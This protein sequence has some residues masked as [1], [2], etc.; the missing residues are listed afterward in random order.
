MTSDKT[1]SLSGRGEGLGGGGWEGRTQGLT[2]EHHVGLLPTSAETTQKGEARPG[3]SLGGERAR[4]GSRG[5]GGR[6]TAHQGWEEVCGLRPRTLGGGR[7]AETPG[8]QRE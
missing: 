6:E 1:G 3:S 2:S 4:S 8:S 5:E 7:S